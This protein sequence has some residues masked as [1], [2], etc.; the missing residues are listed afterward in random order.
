MAN[1][2]VGRSVNEISMLLSGNYHGGSKHTNSVYTGN[3]GSSLL[4]V[5][6]PRDGGGIMTSPYITQIFNGRLELAQQTTVCAP[7]LRG[8]E[9]VK[10][11]GRVEYFIV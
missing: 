4:A 5:S 1:N 11:D 10:G 9:G 2:D 8:E 3:D 6:M 7:V